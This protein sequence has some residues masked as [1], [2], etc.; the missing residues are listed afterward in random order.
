MHNRAGSCVRY[1]KRCSRRPAYSWT[2]P[3]GNFVVGTLGSHWATIHRCPV[4]FTMQHDIDLWGCLMT[5]DEMWR[6]GVQCTRLYMD[7]VGCLA[8]VGPCVPVYLQCC[9]SNG[10]F[11]EELDIGCV[12]GSYLQTVYVPIELGRS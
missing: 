9:P 3:W 7:N 6:M 1:P 2:Q 8:V 11:C 12:G 10:A 5:L 4:W